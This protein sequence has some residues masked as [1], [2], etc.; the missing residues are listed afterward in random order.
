MIKYFHSAFLCAKN[1]KKTHI[2]QIVR[3]AVPVSLCLASLLLAPGAYAQK[4]IVSIHKQNVKVIDV[5]NEIESKTKYLFIYDK[6][7]IKT[8]D[9]VSVDMEQRTVADVLTQIFKGTNILFKQEGQHIVLT[10]QDNEKPKGKQ[11]Q[12]VA[13]KGVVLDSNNE[14]II[15]A[16]ILEKGTVNGTIS[17][18]NGEFVLN[19][20]PGATL[21]FSYIG[22]IN[23][24]EV[25]TDNQPMTIQLKEDSQNLDEVVVVGYGIQKKSVVTAAISRVTS[26]ELSNSTP[27]RIEDVLKGKVSGVQIMQNSGQPGTAS[28]VR[29]RGI[30]TINNSDPLYIVDGMPI[31]SG[32]DYLNPRDIESIEVLKDAAS[33][34]IYGARAANGVILIT[35]KNGQAGKASVNYSFSYGIQNPW[36]TRELLNGQEYEEIMNEAYQNANLSP[37]YA[38]PSATGKGTDWQKQIINNDAPI[39]NHNASISGGTDKASYFVS[40]GYLDQEGIIAKD[41]SNYKRYN[42]RI[43]TD[44]NIFQN[45]ERSFLKKMRVGVNVGY[46]K[47]GS[48]GITE[49]NNFGGP[50]SNAILSPSNAPLYETD[51]AEIKKL[52]DRYGDMLIR[53]EQGQ[54]YK[55]ISGSELTN[56]VAS[57]KIINQRK[58]YH[59]LVGSIWG[60]IELLDQLFF[61][62]SYATDLAFSE[63]TNWSPAY[64]L[65]ETQMDDKSRISANMYHHYT[66]NVENTLRYSKSFGAHNFSAMLGTTL[67]KYTWNNISGENVNLIANIPGKDYLDFALGTKEDQEVSGGSSDHTLASFFGRINYNF[68][69]RYLAEVVLRRDGSSNFPTNHKWAYFP[70]VSLGWN[71]HNEAFFP[72]NPVMNQLKLRASWG[73]N[74]NENI[75]SFQYTSLI[76]PGADYIFNNTTVSGMYPSKLANSEVRWESSEQYDLGIDMRFFNNALSYTLDFFHKSTTGMLMALPIPDYVGNDVPDGNAGSLKNKGVEMEASYQGNVSKLGYTIGINASYMKNEIQSLGF[77][78]GYMDYA[79]FGTLGVIQRHTNGYPIAHY[80]GTPAIG[81]FQNQEQINQYKNAQGQLIQPDAQPGDVIFQDVNNDG[82]INDDDRTYLGKPNPDWTVGF[83]LGL[84]YKGFDFSMF[85]Q[86]AFGGQ[87]FDASRRP[88]LAHVNYSKYILDRWHGEGTSNYY[89]RVV[90]ANQDA[91]NN[92]RVSNLYLYNGNYFRLKN[93]QL[94]YTLPKRITQKFL[95]QDL[96]VYFMAENQ[97]TLTSYHGGDPEIGGDNM[98]VDKG[99]YPQARTLTIGASITF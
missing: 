76:R 18:L 35:T 90:Y 71:I 5:L 80:F 67:H 69:E 81:I 84:N 74:G 44:M 51:E 96:R 7:N 49:N 13:I 26:K 4:A 82:K 48:N 62:S 39:I 29:I 31:S 12:P 34:A 94:G 32:I 98:G 73:K 42:F 3:Q 9:I 77:A 52:E 19:V 64:Y 92:T 88:D 10:L 56:P 97:L 43:N 55:I 36:H 45:E 11:E 6:R 99:I 75:G 50:L 16:N 1:R 28:Q 78:S 22:Y 57:M 30:G 59:K 85:W 41:K 65:S 61:K 47:I 20:Q 53:D 14:P 93:L 89:P 8:N 23:K 72:E 2:Q 38:N 24:E 15:G 58:S 40:F 60:E 95:T 33:A 21:L 37:I 27:T 66:W 68:N 86:G 79:E 46:T 54:L 87:I 17:D 63:E 70:S 91:N 25:A 83:N